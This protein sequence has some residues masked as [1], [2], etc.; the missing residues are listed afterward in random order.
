MVLDALKSSIYTLGTIELGTAGNQASEHATSIESIVVLLMALGTALTALGAAP[1]TGVSL[2]AILSPAAFPAIL[3]AAGIL[4][5][6]PLNTAALTTAL[7]IP[8]VPGV[9][10]GLASAGLLI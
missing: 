2:G 6:D 3:T 9:K 10:P 1:L 7:K 8:K 4:P 5:L